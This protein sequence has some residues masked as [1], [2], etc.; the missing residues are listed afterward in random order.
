MKIYK[1]TEA[2]EYLGVSINTLKFVKEVVKMKENLLNGGEGPDL[3]NGPLKSQIVRC[4]KCGSSNVFLGIP[5]ND[6][7]PVLCYDC[8][9]V[10]FVK[11]DQ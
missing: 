1:I 2:S 7:M 6:G 4:P 11:K 8:K 10:T 3:T 5:E 9:E